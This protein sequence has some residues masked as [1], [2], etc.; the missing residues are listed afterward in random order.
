VEMAKHDK[1]KEAVG[2]YITHPGSRYG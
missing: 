1:V 2:P